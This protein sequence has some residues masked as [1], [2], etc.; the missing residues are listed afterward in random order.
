MRKRDGSF[1]HTGENSVDSRHGTDQQ[2]RPLRKILKQKYIDPA[3]DDLND[4]FY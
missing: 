3:Q 1:K 2:E 4:R